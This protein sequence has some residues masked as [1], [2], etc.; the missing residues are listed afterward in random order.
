ML[1]FA[2]S[3]LMGKLTKLSNLVLHTVRKHGLSNKSVP[4][5]FV[6]FY[7]YLQNLATVSE[8]YSVLF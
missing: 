5:T 3:S 4:I 2:L 6:C 8:E 1:N 7:V